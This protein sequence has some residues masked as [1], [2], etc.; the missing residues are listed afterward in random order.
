MKAPGY[1][2]VSRVGAREVDSF[3]SPELQ[4]ATRCSRD[5]M[6]NQRARG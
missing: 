5:A 1:V 4:R 3:L 2:C 6:V